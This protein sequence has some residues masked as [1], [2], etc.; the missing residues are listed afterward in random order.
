MGEVSSAILEAVLPVPPPTLLPEPEADGLL[1][2]MLLQDSRRAART[3]PTGDLILLE[4]Q[5]RS[6]WNRDQIAEGASLVERA[7]SSR[8]SGSLKLGASTAPAAAI[9]FLL[10]RRRRR[11]SPP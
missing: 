7:L 1:A 6:L 9:F 8:Q 10:A 3:T 2:L 4:D 5:D 11:V